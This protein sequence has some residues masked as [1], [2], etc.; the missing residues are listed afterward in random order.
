[1]ELNFNIK[2]PTNKAEFM[3]LVNEAHRLMDEL[4]RLMDELLA[5]L[6]ADT[7]HLMGHCAP[8]KTE[9]A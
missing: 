1:M 8:Q 5:A 2:K 9:D 3:E 6:R 4:H 7:A